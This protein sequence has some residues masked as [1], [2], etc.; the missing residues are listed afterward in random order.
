MKPR[1]STG[2]RPVGTPSLYA[3]A[4]FNYRTNLF[5]GMTP[6]AS[7]AYTSSR[8]V[9]SRLEVPGFATVDL[10]VRQQ[11]KMGAVHASLRAVAQNVF[12]AAS[13]KVVAA[14]TL[15]PE[16]RRRFTIS[17]AADF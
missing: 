4:D 14:N 17:L 3:R 11:F 16:D 5:G 1:V 8:L 9:S 15:Y 13:W 10:G 6:T 7:F 2:G 12:D